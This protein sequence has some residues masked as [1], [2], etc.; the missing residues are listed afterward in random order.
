M[1]A[2]CV[3]AIIDHLDVV[4]AVRHEVAERLIVGLC[5]KLI[6][7]FFH[8]E[9]IVEARNEVYG[10]LAL[11][12]LVELCVGYAVNGRC[13]AHLFEERCLI[14]ESG[15]EAQRHVSVERRHDAERQAR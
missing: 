1:S 5:R 9:P 8:V 10:P 2:A 14:V 7:P 3:V 6:G 4:H 11:R 13:V 15:S 12:L